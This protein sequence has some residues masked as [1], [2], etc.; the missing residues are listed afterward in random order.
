MKS[1]LSLLLLCFSV[2]FLASQTNRHFTNPLIEDVLLGNYNPDDFTATNI[3]DLPDQIVPIIQEGINS[4][5]LH[6]Y[7]LKLNGFENRNSGSDTLSETFGIGAARNWIKLKFDEISSSNENRLITGFFQFDQVICEMTRHKNVVAALPGRENNREVIIIEAH[8]DSRC[9]TACDVECEARGMEDNGSGTALII[10]LARVMSQFT[11]DKTILFVTTTAEEQGLFGA[12]AMAIY[13]DEDQPSIQVKAVLNNDVIGG[14]ICG[15]TS[16]APSCPGENLIDST[17]VRLFSRGGSNSKHKSLARYLKIQYQQE[18]LPYVQVPMMLTLMSAEDRFGRGGD[19][20]PYGFRSMAAMRF[21]SAHE[22]GDAGIDED[23]HDRQHTSD[24]VLGLDTDEDGVI[25]SFFVD[26]N[27]LARNTR[28]NGVGAAMIASSPEMIEV[29]AEWTSDNIDIIITDDNDIG[30][31]VVGLRTQLNDFDTLIYSDVKEFS[32]PGP[33]NVN[34]ARVSAASVNE[35]EVESCFSNEVF[36][37][38]MVGVVEDEITSKYPVQLMQNAPNP[39]DE[40]TRISAYVSEKF[41]YKNAYISVSSLDGKELE[42][43]NISLEKGEND[44]LYRH[45]YGQIGVY[46]YS[47][48]IDNI[49]VE[50]K[51]MIFA[52]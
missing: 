31:Y 9:E 20:I 3:L 29:T 27:Y 37:L 46:N 47:L 49:I 21:T 25:D 8:M 7:L 19:H 34:L 45:G 38:K 11:F 39:F 5:S 23:Y 22:H 40:A 52:N 30:Q 43:L 51:R 42:K 1:Y 10:E 24:D 28:I 15:A 50:T 35:Q 41:D 4:D 33:T 6:Q 26:F 44:V 13:F 48:I 17:Q 12:T 16:S 18:L 32:I 14:V 2:N 36:L